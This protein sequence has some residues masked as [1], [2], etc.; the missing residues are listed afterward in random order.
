M[1]VYVHMYFGT[2]WDQKRELDPMEL[3]LQAFVTHL[4]W[5]LMLEHWRFLPAESF[6]APDSYFWSLVLL[7]F[8]I[9]EWAL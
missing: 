3:E 2:C 7:Y 9:F 1:W 5:V 8:M 4:T 6:P